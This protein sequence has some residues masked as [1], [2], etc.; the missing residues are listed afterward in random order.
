MLQHVAQKNCGVT[1]HYRLIGSTGPDH[2]KVF[3]VCA[4]VG[5][6]VF[7]SGTGRSKKEAEQAA[8]RRALEALEAESM[9]SAT[10]PS[11]IADNGEKSAQ[12]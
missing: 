9:L 12:A 3:E 2:D 5:H 10:T 4:N 6:R 11:V 1:P 8:A 7:P